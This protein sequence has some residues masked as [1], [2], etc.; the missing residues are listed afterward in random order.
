MDFSQSLTML[1]LTASLLLIITRHL[2]RAVHLLTLQ[3]LALAALAAFWGY[4][5]ANH[6]LYWAAVLTVVVKGLVT[7]WVLLRLLKAIKV[8]KEM[9]MTLPMRLNLIL[10]LLLIL[11]AYRVAIPLKAL[12]TLPVPHSLPVAIAMIMLGLL[13]MITRKKALTQIIGL[14]TMENGLYLSAITAT[15]GMPLVVELGIFFDLL[16]GV[17]LLGIFAYR[18]NQTFDTLNTDTLQSLKG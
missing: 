16:V 1:L 9:E 6:E 17:I 14:I 11:V 15:G 10:A 7:P 8:K 13:L 5:F 3:S 12:A 4:S 18:I 2:A